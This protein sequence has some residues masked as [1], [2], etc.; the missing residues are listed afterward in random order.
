MVQMLNSTFGARGQIGFRSQFVKAE[1]DR[2][3]IANCVFARDVALRVA[4][5]ERV[6]P[7]GQLVPRLLNAYR[8][9]VQPSFDNRAYDTRLFEHFALP[10]FERAVAA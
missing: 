6:L 10:R 9:F 7:L 8:M 5:A 3:D 2:R 1:L 4:G